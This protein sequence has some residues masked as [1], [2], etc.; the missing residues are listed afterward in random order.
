[1]EEDK[2]FE[3]R[4]SRRGLFQDNWRRRIGHGGGRS[5]GALIKGGCR[6]G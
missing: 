1:M 3:E 6:R 4:I 5:A 2:A